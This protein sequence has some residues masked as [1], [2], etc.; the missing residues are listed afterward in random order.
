[1]DI[2]KDP[3]TWLKVATTQEIDLQPWAPRQ[4]TSTT[5]RWRCGLILLPQP[6]TEVPAPTGGW[7]LLRPL[8]YLTQ[9]INTV[10][11]TATEVVK[12]NISKW[13][14]HPFSPCFISSHAQI[15]I[16]NNLLSLTFAKH[17]YIETYK[18]FK[19]IS[20]AQCKIYVIPL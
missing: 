18:L 16:H 15:Q 9:K 13:L 17:N 20:M 12:K 10:I 1:M 11:C 19:F 6:N 5:T 2:L 7:S 3:P 4:W 14:S 8:T